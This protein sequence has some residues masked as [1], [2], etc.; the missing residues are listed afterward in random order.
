MN[1]NY[2]IIMKYT[3]F[4]LPTMGGTAAGLM[5]HKASSHHVAP[6]RGYTCHVA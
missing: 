4:D 5:E 3:L 1:Q 2:Q 6:D